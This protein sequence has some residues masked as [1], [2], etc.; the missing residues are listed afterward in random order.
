MISREEAE[1]MN[2]KMDNGDGCD[3][4]DDDLDNS[5]MIMVV[6]MVYNSNNFCN[7]K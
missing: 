3:E 4:E 1:D 6:M 7:I 5:M 2:T